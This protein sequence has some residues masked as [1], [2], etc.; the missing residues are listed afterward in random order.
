MSVY[1]IVLSTRNGSMV[2]PIYS[3][4]DSKSGFTLAMSASQHIIIIQF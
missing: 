4:V 3:K 2:N 1:S